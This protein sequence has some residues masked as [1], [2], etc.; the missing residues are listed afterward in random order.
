MEARAANKNGGTSN[1]LLVYRLSFNSLLPR[2]CYN[3]PGEIKSTHSRWMIGMLNV[4]SLP[5]KDDFFRLALVH[6]DVSY[7]FVQNRETRYVW[8]KSFPSLHYPTAWLWAAFLVCF[9]W[10][11]HGCFYRRAGGWSNVTMTRSVLL[12]PVQ[13]YALFSLVKFWTRSSN[14]SGRWCASSFD[15]RQSNGGIRSEK[16]HQ[17]MGDFWSFF[18][19]GRRFHRTY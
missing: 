19:L 13:E 5:E 9:L 7:C 11:R 6:P 12:R 1:S 2:I 18:L 4:P 15:V 17:C 8:R 14:L 10:L 16:S 3:V